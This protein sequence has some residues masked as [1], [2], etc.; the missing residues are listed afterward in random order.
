MSRDDDSMVGHLL[1]IHQ[2]PTLSFLDAMA[3]D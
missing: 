1:D 3:G 2:F